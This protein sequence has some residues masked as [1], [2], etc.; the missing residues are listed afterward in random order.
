MKKINKSWDLRGKEFT[1]TVAAFKKVATKY[2][3]LQIQDY[4]SYIDWNPQLFIGVSE[5]SENEIHQV[6]VLLDKMKKISA[7]E[8]E[9]IVEEFVN[10]HVTWY[11]A[12]QNFSEKKA[13]SEI[14]VWVSFDID[15]SE[16][17]SWAKVHAWEMIRYIDETTQKEIS[18][19]ISDSIENWNS[20]DLLKTK[21][22]TKFWKYNETRAA[23]IAQQEI[24]IAF[25]QG[26]RIQY[27][28]YSNYFNT[29]WWKRNMDQW[30]SAVRDSHEENTLEGWIPAD[31]AFKATQTQDEPH[32]FY[33]RCYVD[34]RLTNPD[35]DPL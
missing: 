10:V 28:K 7:E 4:L 30:D 33:C 27:E 1:S 24:S 5:N 3:E 8:L 21:I 23:L 12:G 11:V 26:K 17:I 35:E 25:A 19:I 29:V 16:A 6:E 20:V 31:Q 9:T 14:P 22:Y 32:W 13:Q 18:K 15:N 2:F 34:R